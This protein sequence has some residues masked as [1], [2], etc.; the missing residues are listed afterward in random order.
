MW[1]D[2]MSMWLYLSSRM[3]GD[4]LYHTL[5]FFYKYGDH[6]DLHLLTHSFPTRRSSVLPSLCH[7]VSSP[8][9]PINC[10]MLVPFSVLRRSAR[11]AAQRVPVLC[12]N[13]RAHV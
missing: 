7:S 13:G 6:R 2:G 3:S 1:V 4:S 5:D 11:V 8:S 12:Q 10:S 9:K